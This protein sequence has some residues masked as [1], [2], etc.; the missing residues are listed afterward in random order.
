MRGEGAVPSMRDNMFTTSRGGLNGGSDNK[1]PLLR[2]EQRSSL[3]SLEG[4]TERGGLIG[5][6]AGR[7]PMRRIDHQLV[8]YRPSEC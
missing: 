6:A 5:F 2:I 3:T 8:E 4:L 1:L 7:A